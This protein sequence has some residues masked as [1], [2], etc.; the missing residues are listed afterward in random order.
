MPPDDPSKA[1]IEIAL[2]HLIKPTGDPPDN[3]R[4]MLREWR[5]RVGPNHAQLRRIV[6]DHLMSLGVDHVMAGALDALPT[7]PE[8]PPDAP[9]GIV[10]PGEARRREVPAYRDLL[11]HVRVNVMPKLEHRPRGR[12]VLA[13]IERPH[14]RYLVVCTESGFMDEGRYSLTFTVEPFA[15]FRVLPENV[16]VHDAHGRPAQFKH[17]CQDGGSRWALF[18]RHMPGRKIRAYGSVRLEEAQRW[19]DIP[20][21]TRRIVLTDSPPWFKDVDFDEF[22]RTPTIDGRP[23]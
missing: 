3:L 21:M 2:E 8:P 19:E 10:M 18:V 15:S 5:S 12:A 20:A 6:L 16:I 4:A 17:N 13:P 11:E 22:R 14:G 23:S 7:R 9:D 1:F